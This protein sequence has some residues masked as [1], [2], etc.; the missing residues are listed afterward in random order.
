MK[1][2][3]HF[4]WISLI[5]F[6]LTAANMASDQQVEQFIEL[7]GIEEMIESMPLQIQAI[8]GQRQLTSK[9]PAVEQQVMVLMS[10][11][12]YADEINAAITA[13]IKKNTSATELAKMLEWKKKPLMVKMTEAEAQA[14]APDFQ[15][16]LM[17][18]VATLQSTP[19]TP[20]TREA[21]SRFVDA[22]KMADF[23]VDI[24]SKVVESMAMAF[25]QASGEDTKQA[26]ADLADYMQTMIP[27]MRQQMEQQAIL[28]SYYIYRDISNQEL[29]QYSD[30]YQS[31]LGQKEMNVVT[32]S[33]EVAM[34]LW[35]KK[36]AVAIVEYQKQNK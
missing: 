29:D 13:H 7:S 33:L 30:F 36:S 6:Q 28:T 11:A 16:N 12:W 17:R 9:N 20:E 34:T 26:K 8:S 32:E 23:M 18:Y 10:E 24:S 31:K 14:N 15:A 4:L 21:I 3:L 25:M 22:T 1:S 27:A 5:S 19:P 2:V 35:A